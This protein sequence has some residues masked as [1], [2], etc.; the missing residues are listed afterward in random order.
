M[1]DYDRYDY[2]KQWKNKQIEDLAEKRIL[3]RWIGPGTTCLELGGGF[4]RLTS[5]FERY[6]SR[7]VMLDYSAANIGRASKTAK[8]TELVRAELHNLPFDD[9]QFDNVFLIRVVHH[10]EDPLVVLEEIQRIA[11]DGATV[12]ISAQ[13]PSL[14]KYKHVKTNALVATGDFDHQI[15]LAPLNYYSTKNLRVESILGTGMFENFIGLKLHR[16]TFL[17]AV[18]VLFA[19]LWYLKPNVFMRFRV[20]KM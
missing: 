7:V 6:F 19:P 10:L 9:N 18:D 15:Y 11:K 14:G 2:T 16:L 17:H 3:S 5:F 13:N 4:G 12:V 1:P 8:K 20:M